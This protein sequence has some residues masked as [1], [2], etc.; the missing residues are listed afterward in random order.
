MKKKSVKWL[1]PLLFVCF[2]CLFSCNQTIDDLEEEDSNKEINTEESINNPGPAEEDMDEEELDEVTFDYFNSYDSDIR[3]LDG[4][5]PKVGY[6]FD[7]ETSKQY[8]S[9]FKEGTYMIT[10]GSGY[11]YHGRTGPLDSYNDLDFFQNT[12]YELLSMNLIEPDVLET[13]TVA[14]AFEN[15]VISKIPLSETSVYHVSSVHVRSDVHHIVSYGGEVTNEA[16]EMLESDFFS[17]VDTY[18]LN[19]VAYNQFQFRG[20]FALKYTFEKGAP[21]SK[22]EVSLIVNR[23]WRDRDTSGLSDKELEFFNSLDVEFISVTD[24]LG[25]EYKVSEVLD[26]DDLVSERDRFTNYMYGQPNLR[27]NYHTSV[28]SYGSVVENGVYLVKFLDY[29]LNLLNFNHLSEWKKEINSLQSLTLSEALQ[30][31][32]RIV[33]IEIDEDLIEARACKSILEIDTERF[34]SLVNRSKLYNSEQE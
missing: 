34:E 20:V 15:E 1:S 23:V 9:P 10:Q 32:V 26:S 18:G 22:W 2:T 5:F 7:I 33:L 4:E 24:S 8:P 17:F 25:D 28:R 31:E 14:S 27:R 13:F 16:K 6:G 19:F 3:L 30:E 29:E 21:Y 12:V 11:L